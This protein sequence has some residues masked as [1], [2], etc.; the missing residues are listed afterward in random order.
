MVRYVVVSLASGI[1][2]GFMDGVINANPYA[3]KLYKVYKPIAKTSINVPA[4]VVIDLVY[5]FLM[6]ALGL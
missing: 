2:F 5:G 6:A 3:R 4:G 1:L